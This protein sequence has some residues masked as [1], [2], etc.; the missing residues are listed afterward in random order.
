MDSITVKHIVDQW[1]VPTPSGELPDMSGA[2]MHL[3]RRMQ[4]KL[5]L[6][7]VTHSSA[8]PDAEGEALYYRM[9][10]VD[11]LPGPRGAA[12]RFAGFVVS[13]ETVALTVFLSRL[14][15]ARTV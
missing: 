10:G 6:R 5:L 14:T 4:R 12:T 9:S 11:I 13:V 1:M 8:L 7:F 2:P 15:G 3:E